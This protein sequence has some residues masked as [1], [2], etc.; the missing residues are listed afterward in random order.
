VDLPRSF[1]I[2]EASHRILNP[3]TAGKLATLGSALRLRPGQTMVDL[4]SGKGE[5]LCTWARDHGISGVGIDLSSVFT[6]AAQARAEE[7]GVSDRVEFRHGDAHRFV[8][9]VLAERYDI[10]A[11]IGATDGV[12]ETIERLD[13]GLRPGGMLLIGEPYWHRDPPDEQ[14]VAGCFA[15][16][17]DRF[18]LLPELIEQFR[19]LGWDLVEMVLADGDGWDRYRAAQWLNI[20]TWL[21]ANPADPLAAEL[22]AELHNDP[23]RYARYERPYLGW[24][25][26]A[27]KRST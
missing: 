27:L 15:G 11:C 17:R 6:A 2:R 5:M 7:L 19:T 14:T 9:D 10:G 3:L 26:F 20:R 22:R 16:T 13:R 12:A 1:T 4:G 24:G 18:R 8:P 23:V 21:D 25:I